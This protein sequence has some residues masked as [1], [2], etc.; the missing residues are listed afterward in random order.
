VNKFRVVGQVLRIQ[1]QEI[2][3]LIKRNELLPSMEEPT[4]TLTLLGDLPSDALS[5]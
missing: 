1:D 2:T 4:F 3:V 5:Q